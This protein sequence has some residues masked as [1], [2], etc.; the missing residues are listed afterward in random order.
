VRPAH[1][2]PEVGLDHAR[3]AQHGLGVALRQQ[4]PLRH[5]HH[6]R[7]SDHQVHVVLDDQEGHAL[8]VERRHL[9]DDLVQQRRVDAGA[10]LVQQH[11]LGLRAT[12]TRASSSSLRWPPDSTLA[13]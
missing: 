9:V 6:R 11:Q 10:G 12:I 1:A 4:L 5:H 3:V 7:H 2:S 8:A 13:G